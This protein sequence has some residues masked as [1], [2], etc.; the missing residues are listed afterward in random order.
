MEGAQLELVADEEN[1]LRLSQLSLVSKVLTT[2][3]IRKNVIQFII[4]RVWFT[5]KQ[6]KVVQIHQNTFL[7]CFKTAVDRNKI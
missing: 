5:N 1:A 7:F 6:V 3:T 4:R 2:K